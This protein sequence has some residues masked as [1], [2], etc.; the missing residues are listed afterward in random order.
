MALSQRSSIG[1]YSDPS[2]LDS[3]RV[4][5]VLAEK[6]I[7]VEI[8]EVA[9]GGAQPEDLA[10][11]N[12]YAETPTLVDRDLALYDARVICEYLDERFPH[13]PLMPIDPVSRAKAKLVI[14]RID[15]DWC[16]LIQRLEDG[17]K[18]GVAKLKRDLGESLAASADVFA[19]GT[20]FFLSDE[21][22]MMDCVLAPV[23]WRLPLHGVELPT[24][25]S[26]VTEYADR[27]FQRETFQASLTESEQAMRGGR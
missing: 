10:D 5:L 23:L 11:L 4:R 27:L 15:R 14:S 22:T 20:R 9:P 8:V 17:E 12:P 7:A 19:T 2:A 1:L 21:L 16:R 13:P 18:K 26:A 25:A 24:E 3:H 6:G